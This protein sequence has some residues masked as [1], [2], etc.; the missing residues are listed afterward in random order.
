MSHTRHF[1]GAPRRTAGRLAFAFFLAAL[2]SS[3]N[4]IDAAA[5]SLTGRVVKGGAPQPGVAVEL[6]RIS[7]SNRGV[8]SRATTGADGTF[9]LPLPPADTAAGF[10][11]VF[12]TASV[13]GVRYFGPA[14]HPGDRPAGYEIA[15]HDTTSAA[16]V[17]DSVRV[18]RRDVFLIPQMNGGWE[19]AEVVRIRNPAGRT[20]VPVEGKPIVGMEIPPAADEFQ[21]GEGADSLAGAGLVRMGTRVWLTEPLVPGDRDLFFRYRLP[22]RRGQTAV[23]VGHPTDTL[24]VYVREP[25]PAVRVAGLTDM[26]PL[27]AEG[28]RF[29]RY[30]GTALVPGARVSFAAADARAGGAPV[31]PRAAA[32]AVAAVILAA[33]AFLAIRRGRTAA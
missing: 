11:V 27:E 13:D 14:L 18:S 9:R 25:G 23:P 29:A 28:E 10:A 5:Q 12:A 7:T 4:S 16:G 30:G 17:A 6:H 26:D 1:R 8:T 33:G 20:L 22:A 24:N 15:V 21:A 3:I 31:D 2:L 19:V 32:L